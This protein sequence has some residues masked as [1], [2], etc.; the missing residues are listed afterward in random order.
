MSLSPLFVRPFVRPTP[1]GFRPCESF[2][3]HLPSVHLH[4]IC[5]TASHSCTLPHCDGNKNELS[6]IHD[7]F[8]V[9]LPTPSFALSLSPWL[10]FAPGAQ[11]LLL[12]GCQNDSSVTNCR[13]APKVSLGHFLFLPRVPNLFHSP[14]H[15]ALS[16]PSKQTFQASM[17]DVVPIQVHAVIGDQPT[18]IAKLVVNQCTGA[19]VPGW[20]VMLP[21]LNMARAH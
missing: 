1:V 20:K 10:L 16:A 11:N 4:C 7:V 9:P 8:S 3:G 21:S 12:P 18:A 2:F 5:H 15:F 17:L 6:W 13:G 19:W 14:M